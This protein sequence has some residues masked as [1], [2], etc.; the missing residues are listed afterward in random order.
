MRLLYRQSYKERSIANCPPLEIIVVDDGSTDD[1]LQSCKGL[2]ALCAASAENRGLSGARN[3]GNE[4]A[5][6][7]LIA[8]TGRR[9]HVAAAQIRTTA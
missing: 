2:V 1:T 9:R 4:E 8:L 6:G 5:R 7:D 3:R